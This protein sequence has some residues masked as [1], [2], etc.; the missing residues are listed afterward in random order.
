MGAVDLFDLAE[1]ASRIDKFPH[2][3]EWHGCVI[4]S[5]DLPHE[6]DEVHEVKQ[7][8]VSKFRSS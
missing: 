5:D 2:V 1:L 3:V 6:E 4:P 7:E 8:I